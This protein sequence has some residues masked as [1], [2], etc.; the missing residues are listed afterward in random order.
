MPSYTFDIGEA[1]PESDPVA[2]FV[3]VLAM[4]I[5]D[6]HRTMDRMASVAN[7]DPDSKDPEAI[8]IKV[9]LARQE[10]AACFEAMKFIADSRRRFPE[11]EAFVK[12]MGPKAQEYIAAV[13][14]GVDQQSPE[15]QDWLEGHRNV[16]SHYP[17]I[18]PKKYAAGKEEIANAL[19][20]AA[21]VEA[22][23]SVTVGDRDST[24]RFHYA[25]EVAVQLLPDVTKTPRLI[26]ALADARK[27]IGR[28]AGLAFAAYRAAHAEAFTLE[29][30]G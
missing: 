1:F 14:A 20:R 11:V 4:V 10:A 5:N 16:T 12:G 8:G 18:S 21:D 22:R 13:E 25:D 26:E 3:T 23:G 6:W 27:A 17:E 2:R 30:D 15:Y 24:L 28:F 9:G 29:S 7:A 19:K